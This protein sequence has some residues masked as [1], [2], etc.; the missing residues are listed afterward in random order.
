MN[1]RE[2][3]YK[4]QVEMS[5]QLKYVREPEITKCKMEEKIRNEKELGELSNKVRTCQA[6]K[7]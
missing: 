4:L 5:Q 7:K 1:V 3:E 2:I 6:K